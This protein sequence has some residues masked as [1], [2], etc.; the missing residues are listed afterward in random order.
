MMNIVNGG[1]HADNNVDLQEFMIMPIG[2]VTFADALKMGAEVFHNLKNILKSKKLSTEAGNFSKTFIFCS[3]ARY[4]D[5][6]I[7]FKTS[8]S[9]DS[10][11]LNSMSFLIVVSVFML[12]GARLNSP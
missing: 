9:E 12:P 1:M 3:S 11:R 8:M 4:W 5:T 7:F 6:A 2:A 10:P